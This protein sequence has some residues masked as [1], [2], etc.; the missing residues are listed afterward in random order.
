M[1]SGQ[2]P[3]QSYTVER[4][5]T[6]GL[7]SGALIANSFDVLGSRFSTDRILARILN[8]GASGDDCVF[9]SLRASIV[10]RTD[11]MNEI[12]IG[13]TTFSQN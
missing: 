9:E 11:L 12:C 3:N 6:R 7:A 5:L 2:K 4:G 10:K 8:V 1:S 13:K